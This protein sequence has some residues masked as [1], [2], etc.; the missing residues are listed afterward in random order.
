LERFR[1]V[2][3]VPSTRVGR[4]VDRYWIAS[5]DLAEPYTQEILAHPVVNIVFEADGANI[6]GV[7][8]ER[9]R[10]DLTGRGRAVGVM[11]RPGGF[12][13]FVD[14]PMSALVGRSM[15]FTD[16]FPA[17]DQ[18]QGSVPM[19]DDDVAVRRIDE[20]LR[21]RL[22][23][24]R[25]PGED[26]SDLVEE[27]AA[28]RSIQRVDDLAEEHGVSVRH[29]QRLFA[30]Y[31]GV[32]PKSVIRRYRLYDAAE[33]VARGDEV[34]WADLALS[35]GY[36]DQGHLVRDFTA[37]VGVPPERYA[38]ENRGAVGSGSAGAATA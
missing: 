1:L 28:D 38:R 31:I 10:K 13:A 16:V 35:L 34:V 11:F 12:R 5:W 22:P 9:T 25:H 24:E 21:G 30:E 19:L 37:A 18:L 3:R 27:I 20:F 23:A 17:G 7:S 4:F 29:L 26:V 8:V 2:R 36:S 14:V 32:G 15:S 33:A 6:H